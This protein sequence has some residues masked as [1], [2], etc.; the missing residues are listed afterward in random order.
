MV[1][2][3]FLVDSQLAWHPSS[4]KTAVF[5]KSVTLP[6]LCIKVA[7]QY[8][9]KQTKQHTRDFHLHSLYVNL[10]SWS[11]KTKVR[12]TFM[13]LVSTFCSS[14]QLIFI[15][16]FQLQFSLCLPQ[17]CSL[18][19]GLHIFTKTQIWRLWTEIFT[20]LLTYKPSQQ[21]QSLVTTIADEFKQMQM[22]PSRFK[23]T[24]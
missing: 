9:N 1:P 15:V 6:F 19:Y 21:T 16:Y 12:R 2:G 13:M 17:P 20:N 3:G 14:T 11:P 18:L 24:Y 8:E 10:Y 23:M 5:I 22:L 7:V 4:T